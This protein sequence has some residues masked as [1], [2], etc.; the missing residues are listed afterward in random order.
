[1]GFTIYSS[2]DS[3]APTLNGLTGSLLSVLDAC[4]VNGYGTK[5]AAGWTKPLPNTSSYGCYKQGTGSLFYLFAY[6][7]GSGSAAGTEAQMSGWDSI[8]SI[9]N[10]SVTGNNPFP[11][12]GQLTIGPGTGSASGAVIYRKSIAPN[13]TARTWIVFADSSS[14]YMFSI[15]GDSGGTYT[16]FSFGDFYSLRSGS[17]DTSRCLIIGRSVI[18]SSTITS[19]KLDVLSTSNPMTAT[20]GHFAAHTFSG[21]SGS[22]TLSKHGDGIK[23]GASGSLCGV[24]QYLNSVDNGLYISPVWIVETAIAS[25]RGRMRGF[26][27]LCHPTSSFTDGQVFSGSGDFPNRTFRVIVPTGNNGAY[28]METSDTLETN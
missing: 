3:G 6:D 28:F 8:T 21:A 17:V 23:G 18:S 20:A 1:M 4:L 14:L 16:G 10:G 2:S 19:D 15:S 12:Y 25:V 9:V 26:Y 24:I 13:A 7:A 22:I 5:I 27:H 11:T